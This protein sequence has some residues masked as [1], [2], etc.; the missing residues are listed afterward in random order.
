MI[1]IS[2]AWVNGK[3]DEKVLWLVAKLRECGFEAKCDVMF[4]GERTS[5][6]FK[7]MMAEN[8]QKADKIIVILSEIYKKKADLFEGGVG[9]EYKYILE[10]IDV[11]I[12]KYSLVSFKNNLSES[13]IPDFFRGREIIYLNNSFEKLI[14]RLEDIP[15][16]IFPEVNP[17]EIAV[18][19]NIISTIENFSDTLFNRRNNLPFIRNSF[20]SSREDILESIHIN[21]ETY[22][23]RQIIQILS[24]VGGV[25]K[26]QIAIEYA[27]SFLD[28]YPLIWWIKSE[29]K[30]GIIE[31]FMELGRNLGISGSHL[32]L[33]E[34]EK[35]AIIIKKLNCVKK[36][37]L[38]FDNANCLNEIEK[39]LPKSNV[40]SIL[41]TSRDNNWKMIG[42]VISVDVFTPQEALDFIRKRTLI[43]DLSGAEVLSKRLGF[44]PLAMEQAAA[45]IVNNA[46]SFLDYIELFEKYKL[47]LFDLESSKPLNYTHTVTITSR[48]SINRINNESSAQLLKIISFLDADSIELGFFTNSEK[49][50]PSPLS[51]CIQNELQTR[52]IIWELKRYSLIKE[53]DGKISIHRLLQE[54]MREEGGMKKYYRYGFNIIMNSIFIDEK[55]LCFRATKYDEF[56]MFYPHILSLCKS[57]DEYYYECSAYWYKQLAM[58]FMC[59]FSSDSPRGSIIISFVKGF[60]EIIVLVCKKINDLDYFIYNF[61]WLI[62]ENDSCCN[63]LNNM[64]NIFLPLLKHIEY[65]PDDISCAFYIVLSV[66]GGRNANRDRNKDRDLAYLARAKR[67]YK[68]YGRKGAVEYINNYDMLMVQRYKW[69]EEFHNK[70]LR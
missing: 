69:D 55:L 19:P 17:E 23:D 28:Y 30:Q 40:G 64:G 44:L 39:Y 48:L 4:T 24:G 60:F 65:F 52:E 57:M 63:Y 15:E 8:M 16:Y 35:I 33:D 10:D 22:E 5:I 3:P 61:I 13:E 37:L 50:L 66:I 43:N 45:Y 41:I 29:T 36:Y 38:I 42:N 53:E 54:V 18:K 21:F 7:Q 1:F 56:K 67:I 11:N 47:K 2:H 20:F 32:N 9:V 58:W 31:S 51:E 46:L 34:D 59:L 14:Y 68:A 25:G 6:H 26:T 12:G 27:Y 70:L 49:I 62:N